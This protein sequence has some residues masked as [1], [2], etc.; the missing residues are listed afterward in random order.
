MLPTWFESNLWQ[1]YVFYQMTRPAS[2]T[3][4]VGTRVTEAAAITI[5][6]PIIVSPFSVK[7]SAQVTPSCNAIN[8]YLD[9]TENI[10]ADVMFEATNKAKATNYNDQT[11]M[12][13]P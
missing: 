7:G 8:N 1:R 3:I 12:V 10:D 6:S 4:T 13:A 9:S 2:S 11:F 5:G